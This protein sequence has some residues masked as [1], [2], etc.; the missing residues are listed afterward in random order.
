MQKIILFVEPND[1]AFV[2][3]EKIGNLFMNRFA[4]EEDGSSE[5]LKIL[6]LGK[7][8]W[9]IL[10]SHGDNYNN[11]A[12]RLQKGIDF[13]LVIMKYRF[14]QFNESKSKTP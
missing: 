11:F 13:L 9:E 4:I 6:E 12:K 5:I 1:E 2:T 7:T 3:P 14:D 10:S 8:S